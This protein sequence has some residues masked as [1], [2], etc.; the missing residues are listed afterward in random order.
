MQCNTFRVVSSKMISTGLSGKEV[1]ENIP[2]LDEDRGN[3]YLFDILRLEAEAVRSLIDIEEK[4]NYITVSMSDETPKDLAYSQRDI[5]DIDTCMTSHLCTYKDVH[6]HL[7]SRDGK[8]V[9]HIYTWKETINSETMMCMTNASYCPLLCPLSWDRVDEML[10]HI[11]K[12]QSKED[13]RYMTMRQISTDIT[14]MMIERYNQ[15]N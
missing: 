5:L 13:I 12:F 11:K 7:F 10:A 14:Q 4:E 15:K 2:S 9:A 3:S 6:C 1:F 8:Y